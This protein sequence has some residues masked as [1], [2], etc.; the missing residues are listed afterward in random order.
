MVRKKT[1]KEL[2]YQLMS[3]SEL[4]LRRPAKYRKLINLRYTKTQAI[5]ILRKET[6]MDSL[7]K[8]Q[9]RIGVARH[10]VGTTGVSLAGIRLTEKV[11][12]Y[13][14]ELASNNIIFTYRKGQ[15]SL[16]LVKPK[17]WRS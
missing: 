10:Q 17:V 6:K 8:L 4:I 15:Q 16:K 5:K 13:I 9:H 1:K 11:K 7:S 14:K 3:E 12:R 2:K